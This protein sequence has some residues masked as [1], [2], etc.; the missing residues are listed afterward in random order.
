VVP[1]IR[2][3]RV[4]ALL[5]AIA[6]PARA[7]DSEKG[8]CL[9]AHEQGQVARRGGHF[10]EARRLFGRCML[11]ACPTPV[12][13]RCAELAQSVEA[14]QPS[15][16]LAARDAAGKDIGPGARLSI[17]GGAPRDLPATALRLDP[18]EHLLR[19]EVEGRA[20]IEARVLVREGE[21]E[22]RIEMSEAA[23]PASPPTEHAGTPVAEPSPGQDSTSTGAP[24]AAWISAALSG[25][26]LVSA[27]TTSAIG[28]GI[29]SH[30]SGTCSPACSQE[31][32]QP[33]RVLWPVSFVAL[34][35]GLVSG[36]VAAV[37]FVK[38]RDS[39]GARAG[40]RFDPDGGGWRF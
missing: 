34:G 27:A 11:D 28:W 22:R 2:A 4:A 37:L 15:V 12:R 35:V 17:D 32:V 29:R 5:V 1:L 6:V 33:L 18:G 40:L 3:T 14:V 19:I 23:A 20:A 39:A 13:K 26:A 21:R 8:D 30:L 25:V 10:D 24:L 31:Q 38:P 9:A 36:A 7:D 16:I